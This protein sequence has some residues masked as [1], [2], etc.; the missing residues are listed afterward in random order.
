MVLPLGAS[1]SPGGSTE[2]SGITSLA[3]RERERRGREDLGGGSGGSTSGV[4][5]RGGAILAISGRRNPSVSVDGAVGLEATLMGLLLVRLELEATLMGRLLVR[6]EL[7]LTLMG[8]LGAGVFGAATAD[9]S[10]DGIA[11]ADD[12]GT[13]TT[14]ITPYGP[15]ASDDAPGALLDAW[16]ALLLRRM[17]SSSLV[18]D[19]DLFLDD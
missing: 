15:E 7:E 14:D 8:R 10:S 3:A 6:L 5:E 16:G 1:L 19:R 18:R 2:L 12:A 17:G 9:I 11:F 13:A 4:R